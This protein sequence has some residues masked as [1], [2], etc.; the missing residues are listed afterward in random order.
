MKNEI[1]EYAF[2]SKMSDLPMARLIKDTPMLFYK[3]R[4]WNINLILSEMATFDTDVY[5]ELEFNDPI[6]EELIEKLVLEEKLSLSRLSF[7][8]LRETPPTWTGK[9]DFRHRGDSIQEEFIS[10]LVDDLNFEFFK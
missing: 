1:T 2:I 4:H 8:Q 6:L 7:R 5:A 10:W 3:G 9:P